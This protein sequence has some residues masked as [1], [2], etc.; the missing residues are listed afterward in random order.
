MNGR[1]TLRFDEFVDA[2]LYG[3]DGFYASGRGAG[4]RADFLTSPE[5]GPLFG[6]VIGQA[7]DAWWAELGRPDPF[8]VVEA[9][10]GRGTLAAAVEASYPTCA[11]AL[12]Y[13]LV[14]RCPTERDAAPSMPDQPF[15]GVVLANELLDNLA[16]RL[17]ELTT[18]GWRE[19]HVVR[20]ADGGLGEV[21]APTDQ[22]PA[23]DARG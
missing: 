13:R 12:D 2:A 18:D 4:R 16:F 15:T 20:A 19:V 22:S 6:A 7:L 3:S 8:V 5:V 1:R 17:L 11:A 23:V 9:G 10:A 21:L 14:E